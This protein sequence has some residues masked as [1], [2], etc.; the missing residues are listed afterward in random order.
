MPS[1][2]A[3][4]KPVQK[5]KVVLKNAV[6]KNAFYLWV[7]MSGTKMRNAASKPSSV[8]AALYKKFK[9]SRIESARRDAFLGSVED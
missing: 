4:P 9:N 2:I 3:K 1:T 8:D 5:K 6:E 7:W